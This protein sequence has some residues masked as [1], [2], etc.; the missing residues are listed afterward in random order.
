MIYAHFDGDDVGPRLELLL[1]DD[2]VEEA[3]SY[4]EGV[5]K[6]L[7]AL[8]EMACSIT[9]ADVVIAGG[10]DLIVSWSRDAI[11]LDQIELMRNA[12][13]KVSG[14]TVSVGIGFSASEATSNLR[15]AKL[16]GKDKIVAPTVI[17]R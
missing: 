10:D 17:G 16:M 11:D 9:T 6:G 15:R 14:R 12:F 4:S 8:S 1:L 2:L 3:R 7:A 13:S 5:N